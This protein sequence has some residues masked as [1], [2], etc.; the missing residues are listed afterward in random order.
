MRGGGVES[1]NGRKGIRRRDA[2]ATQRK[3][4]K[5]SFFSALIS[6][7][8]SAPRRLCVEI[9]GYAAKWWGEAHRLG[10]KDLKIGSPAASYIED[11]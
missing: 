4:S 9:L 11:K 5:W 1:Q 6:A 7:L 3:L 2:E 8:I 10:K